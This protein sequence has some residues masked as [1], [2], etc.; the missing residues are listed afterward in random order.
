MLEYKWLLTQL[1]ICKMFAEENSDEH[2]EID[3][4]FIFEK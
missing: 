2:N 1:K 4:T 3:Q